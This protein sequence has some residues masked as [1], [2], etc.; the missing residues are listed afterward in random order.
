[1]YEERAMP[2]LR[3]ALL[4]FDERELRVRK[5]YLEEQN[6]ALSCS[7]FCSGGALL[8]QLRQERCFDIVVLSNQLEDMDGF[9]FINRLNG[10]RSHPLLLLQGDG[11][12]GETTAACLK[13]GSSYLLQRSRLQELLQDLRSMPAAGGDRVEEFGREMLARWD[14]LQPDVNC[15]YLLRALRIACGS[16]GKL[17]L[18]KEVLQGV[19]EEYQVTVAAVDSGLRRLIEGLEQRSPEGWRQFKAA[20]GLA[21]RKVSTGKLIYALRSA[22]TRGA[23]SA[24]GM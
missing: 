1:M 24:A 7:C 21:D 20:N 2:K 23:A 15:G 5:N 11:W 17:A 9:E 16:E 22:Y 12:Y 19:A 10:L 3:V 8:Q 14:I 4:S 13:P 6:P 18:R